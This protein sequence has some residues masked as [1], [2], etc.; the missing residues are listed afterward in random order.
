MTFSEFPTALL[1]GAACDLAGA[2]V[3]RHHVGGGTGP[4]RWCS[5]PTRDLRRRDV[6]ALPA[7]R[8]DLRPESLSALLRRRSRRRHNHLDTRRND[9]RD[10][11][12]SR[13]LDRSGRVVFGDGE[14]DLDPRMALGRRLLRDVIRLVRQTFAA[15]RLAARRSHHP[16]AGRGCSR[17][18]GRDLG[19]AAGQG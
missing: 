11:G 18:S 12:V 9:A 13:R 7:V 19:S 10:R 16:P 6:D 1:R 4:W 14:S 17:N 8:R 2:L 3:D 15:R 5:R